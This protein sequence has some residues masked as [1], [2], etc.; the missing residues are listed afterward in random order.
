MF[1][2]KEDDYDSTSE[3]IFSQDQAGNYECEDISPNKTMPPRK[4]YLSVN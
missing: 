1:A 3:M 2:N 4:L